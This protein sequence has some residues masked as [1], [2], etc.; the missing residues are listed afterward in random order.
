M[1][2]GKKEEC[3]GGKGKK[4]GKGGGGVTPE[5]TPPPPAN[6]AALRQHCNVDTELCLPRRKSDTAKETRVRY[7]SERTLNLTKVSKRVEG[8]G[9]GEGG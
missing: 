9:A 3:D 5:Q 4:S 2:K 7:S 6:T 8:G 1:Q